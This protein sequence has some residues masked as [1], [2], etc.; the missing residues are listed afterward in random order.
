[1]GKYR[2]NRF[3]RPVQPMSEEEQCLPR[4]V[5]VVGPTAAGKTDLALR[6]AHDL[7][8]P[9]LCC[10][11]VQVYRGLDIGSAKPG[12]VER[13]RVPHFLLD[14]IDPDQEFSAGD[15][16][17][18]AKMQLATGPGIFCGGTGFYLR[19]ALWSVSGDGAS[20]SALDLS[21]DE[22]LRRAFER[23]WE[24]R[25]A[26]KEGAVHDALRVADAE[27]AGTIHPNNVVRV[28]RALWHCDRIGGP[29]SDFRRK[30][31]PRKCLKLMIIV[32]DPG[33]NEVDVS[34]GARCDA[35]FAAG[36]VEEVEKLL[37][38]GYDASYKAMR[39]LGYRQLVDH[40]RAPKRLSLAEVA[41]DIKNATR[42]YAR[43]Q[44]TFFRHQFSDLPERQIVHISDP[45]D[46]PV[47]PIAVF[48][49]GDPS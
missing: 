7:K 25:E 16:A 37:A 1:M 28:L 9:I 49:R 27:T 4:A 23:T 44:R 38:A 33:V 34:I 2:E 42:H 14:L 17:R 35:M 19:S 13:T 8:L 39:S 31:P 40:L 11:S 45:N 24:A 29:L 36:W 5:A 15:Y 32:V 41:L 18:A 43:R 20:G 12:Q 6:L 3:W 21:R 46:C 26:A 10:D 30:N 22:P 48:L 47:D